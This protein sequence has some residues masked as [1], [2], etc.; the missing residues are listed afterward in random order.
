MK[1][2]I[3]AKQ[4]HRIRVAMIVIGFPTADRPDNGI[5]NLRAARALSH[6]ADLTVLYLRA[7]KPSRRRVELSDVDGIR[8]VT[9]AVPQI[10]RGGNLNIALYRYLGWPLVRPFLQ[11]CNLIHSVDAAL[12]GT[13]A[14][15]WARLARVHHVTQ[16][17]FDSCLLSA[18]MHSP[19]VSGWEQHVHGVACNSRALANGFLALYDQVPNVRAVYR[20]VDLDKYQPTEPNK[21]PLSDREP[22]VFLFLGGFPVEPESAHGANRKGFETL[23]AAWKAAEDRLLSTDA[24]LVLAGL[25][26]DAERVVR[27]RAGLR[28]PSRVRLAGHLHPD[29]VP[30]YINSSNVVLVPSLQEGLP[31]VAMEASACGR[32]VFGSD[33]AGMSEVI[34]D[35][36]TGVL[37]TAGDVSAWKDALVT[38]AGQASKLR[39]MGQR[40]RRRMQLLFDSRHYA[41]EML[42]LYAAALREPLSLNQY[43]LQNLEHE[44]IV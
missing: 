40:A 11:S 2:T 26:S 36:D 43:K 8:V 33:I 44:E 31:N 14:S 38:Y 3:S 25:N 1:E 20:G 29:M 12:V 19:L 17:I 35:G 9:F 30:A 5:F 6:S 21:S 32:P 10:P 7:W 27:W 15:T 18:R 4:A 24:S 22:T 37:L 34:V 28:E 41:T 39:A 42:D 23:L 16:V 13:I